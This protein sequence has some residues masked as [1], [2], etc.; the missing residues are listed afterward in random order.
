MLLAVDWSTTAALLAVILAEGVRRLPAGS[1][2]LRRATLGGWRIVHGPT[3]RQSWRLVSAWAPLSE[4]LIVKTGGA[5]TVVPPD[6]SDP[7]F[8]APGMPSR[9]TTAGLRLAGLVVLVLVAFGIPSATATFGA[10]GLLRSLLV[11][12]ALSGVVMLLTATSLKRAAGGWLPAL[13]RTKSLVSPFSAPRAAELL[14]QEIVN[15]WS[16]AHA[17]RSLV[18]REDFDVWYRAHAYDALAIASPASADGRTTQRLRQ[19]TERVPRD[20]GPGERFCPRCAAVFRPDVSEC[21]DCVAVPLRD[22]PPQA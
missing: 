10:T 2:V 4:H 9:L 20:C 19:I 14:H 22:G 17:L 6:D 13:A 8:T 21:S 16:A 5:E 11:V 18:R 7:E 1:V 3:S 12:V 15:D